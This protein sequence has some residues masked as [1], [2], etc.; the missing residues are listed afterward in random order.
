MSSPVNNGSAETLI[1]EGVHNGPAGVQIPTVGERQRYG[2]D[3]VV[4]FRSNGATR[5][6]AVGDVALLG[7]VEYTIAAVAPSS[8]SV[9]FERAYLALTAA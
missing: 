4:A 2:C 1:I 7:G 3:R 8:V 6:A 9:G 5:K